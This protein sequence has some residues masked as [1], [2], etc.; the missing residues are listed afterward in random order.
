MRTTAGLIVATMF[1]TA[2]AALSVSTG[3]GAALAKPVRIAAPKVGHF[4][5]KAIAMT[6]KKM[7]KLRLV[8]KV[9]KSLVVVVGVAADRKHKGKYYG[10][11]V[12]LNRKLSAARKVQSV[13]GA[14]SRDATFFVSFATDGADTAGPTS[15][16]EAIRLA[17]TGDTITFRSQFLANPISVGA[18]TIMNDGFSIG[19]GTPWDNVDPAAGLAVF[20]NILGNSPPPPPPPPSVFCSTSFLNQGTLNE[21]IST[22]QCQAGTFTGLL[23]T[24]LGGNRIV[25]QFPEQGQ[26]TCTVMSNGSAYCWFPSP[27]SS[28]GRIDLRFLNAPNGVQVQRSTNGGQSYEPGSWNSTGP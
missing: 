16:R 8:G 4:S 22:T 26:A 12:M 3:R 1:V 5:V 18:P 7:P 13:G 2:F 10:F 9:P 21:V 15:L 11:I 6:A 23:F 14:S 25:D 20:N 27:V 24:P 28:S 17:N 19:T